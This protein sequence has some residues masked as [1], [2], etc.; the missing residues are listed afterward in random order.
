MKQLLLPLEAKEAQ[1]A[2]ETGPSALKTSELVE[3]VLDLSFSTK[4]QRQL[5]ALHLPLSQAEFAIA[6]PEL[7]K[8]Q[9]AQ[10]L[11]AIELG[12]RIERSKL[13]ENIEEPAIT[14]STMAVEYCRKTF[15]QLTFAKQEEFHI[16]SLNTKNRVI[17]THQVTVGTLDSSLVHPREVFRPAIAMLQHP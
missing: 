1:P 6:C 7:T 16:I 15:R 11:I 14:S 4:S 5:D 2:Y 10:L 12:K 13:A 9:V 8:S 17:A 3:R